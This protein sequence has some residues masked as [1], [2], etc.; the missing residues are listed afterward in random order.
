MLICRLFSSDYFIPFLNVN[1]SSVLSLICFNGS[2]PLL[3]CDPHRLMCLVATVNTD[4][5]TST[6]THTHTLHITNCSFQWI[7]PWKQ[8]YNCIIM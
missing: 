4:N 5:N 1:M 3:K 7:W 2:G 6:H 8:C